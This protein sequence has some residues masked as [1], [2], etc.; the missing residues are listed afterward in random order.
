[1]KKF[2]FIFA[3]VIGM[4]TLQSCVKEEIIQNNNVEVQVIELTGVNFTSVNGY[5]RLFE[6][7]PAILDNDMVLVYLLDSVDNNTD[8]WRPLPQVYYLEDNLGPYEVRYNFDFT[9]FDV[10]LFMT[11]DDWSAVSPAY[12]TNQ[13]FRVVIL[14][15]YRARSASQVDFND[16]NAVVKAYNLDLSKIKKVKM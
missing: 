5:S 4:I 14:P 2:Y 11:S 3:I 10:R 7:N 6:F 9:K 16:F 1:M 13:I 12:T 15:G 8:I